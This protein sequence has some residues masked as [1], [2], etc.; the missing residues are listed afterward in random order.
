[1]ADTPHRLCT[2][3]LGDRCYGVDVEKVQE[4][5]RP[6]A[7]TR[8]PLAPAAI[9]GLINLRGQ[10]LTAIDLRACLGIESRALDPAE[11]MNLVMRTSHGTVSFLVDEIGDVIEVTPEISRRPPETLRGAGRELI[12]AA[13]EHPG[14]LILLLDAEKAADPESIAARPAMAN[15][16]PEVDR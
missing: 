3:T 4:I 6:H 15:Q 11:S 14:T 7:I 8:V 2:F 5:L 9:R 12:T 13:L 1:M 16:T 10:I